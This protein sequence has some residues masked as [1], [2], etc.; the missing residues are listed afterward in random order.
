[1]YVSNCKTVCQITYNTVLV[2]TL[3]PAQSMLIQ[4]SIPLSSMGLI[5]PPLLVF[6]L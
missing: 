5:Y 3:N 2:E 6:N 1:M 4:L